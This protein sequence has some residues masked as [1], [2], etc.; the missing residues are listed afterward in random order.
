M[1]GYPLQTH[2]GPDQIHQGVS[3]TLNVLVCIPFL[4]IWTLKYN[5]LGTK[6]IFCSLYEIKKCY[7]N[8]SLKTFLNIYD[9]ILVSL[10]I[11]TILLRD[12]TQFLFK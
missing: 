3:F 1:I 6:E 12:G 10:D 9:K 7:E 2:F 5:I 11:V 4:D 8:V